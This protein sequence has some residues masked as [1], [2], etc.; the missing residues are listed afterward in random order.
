M[1]LSSPILQEAICFVGFEAVT[2]E[3]M[4]SA[5]YSRVQNEYSSFTPLPQ[6][7][8]TVEIGPD[9]LLPP[10]HSFQQFMRY[11][12]KGNKKVI[13]LS[14]SSLALH[15]LRPY[16]GWEAVI[17]ELRHVWGELTEIISPIKVNLLTLRYINVIPFQSEKEALNYWLV[18]NDFLPTA[19]LRSYPLSPCHV[20]ENKNGGNGYPSGGD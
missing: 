18:P 14:P 4:F 3:H 8:I 5:F 1:P 16:P 2:D 7:T 20:Q 6:Q 13:T 11:S 19:V 17:E 10:Q 15:F 9:G 12:G